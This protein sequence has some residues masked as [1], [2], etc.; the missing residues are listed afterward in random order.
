MVDDLLNV[1]RIQSGK[2]VM[3]LEK[4]KLSD[5]FEER[6]AIAQGSTDKHQFVIDIETGLPPVLVDRDKFG[7]VIGNLLNNAVKYSPNGGRITLSARHE[8]QK[9][10][11]VVSV[12]DRGDRNRAGG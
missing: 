8:P 2:V 9:H 5:I 7:E 1:T 11:V 3:K 6:L 12:M 10:H 4:V